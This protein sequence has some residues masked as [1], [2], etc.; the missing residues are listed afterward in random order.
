MA[1]AISLWSLGAWAASPP[2]AIAFV[3]GYGT[4][5]QQVC[6]LDPAGGAVVPVGPGRNDG[7]PVW[8][9]R[10]DRL[11]FETDT[12]AG[13]SIAVVNA[14]G[15]GLR[16]LSHADAMNAWPR[17]DGSGSRLA[18][19]AGRGAG[20]R[21]VIYD[22]D[23]D[24]ELPWGG[25]MRGLLHPTWVRAEPLIRTAEGAGDAYAELAALLASLGET[26][27]ILAVGLSGGEGNASTDLFAVTPQGA[28]R[29]PGSEPGYVEWA[30]EPDP[31]ARS[32]A[33]E[34][35]DGGDREIYVA[36]FTK[37]I[38]NVSNHRAA[39]WNPVWAPDG[40]WLA[41]ESF[42]GGRRG[43]Y[44]TFPETSRVYEVAASKDYDNWSPSWSP[45]G[46]RLVFVSD[47]AGRPGLYICGLNGE[48]VR[49]VG[50]KDL[51]AVAP[52]WRPEG[53]DD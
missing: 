35:N 8:S 53:D 13:R 16:V 22:L 25:P 30:L 21:V 18:Y 10:G 45:D 27:I 2:D 4:P 19:A 29:L 37:G 34:S 42:R 50:P 43:I 44:R 33:Y 17:W 40:K 24:V 11:A 51:S 48:N 36:S 46:K 41:F 52:A 39:D 49:P 47:R 6:V 31:R 12:D 28:V 7:A 26:Y 9:P 1:L 15:S 3:A 23:R 5:H 38:S 14:D 32:V 20:L